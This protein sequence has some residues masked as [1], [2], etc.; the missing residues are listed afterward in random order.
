MKT[1]GGR[2]FW[3]DVYAF[4]DWRIQQNVLTGHFRLLDGD[5]FRHAS[6]TFKTCRRKLDEIRKARNLPPMKGKAVIVVHGIIRSSKSFAKM[7]EQLKKEGFTVIGFDYPSTRVEITKSAN[8]LHK[9]ITSLKGIEEINFVVHSMGG[10]V[11]RAY[12]INHR[13]KRIRRMVMLGVPNHGARMAD[14]LKK[15]PLFRLVLGPAGQQLV[16]DPQGVINSLPIPDFEFGIVAG[17]RGTIKGYNPLIPGDD[18]GTVSVS[19]ARLAGARDFIT[20]KCLHSFLM[21]HPRTIEFTSRFLREGRFR[22]HGA[23]HPIPQ[24]KNLRIEAN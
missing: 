5:D 7:R 4:H 16:S 6:G 2:Q 1:L 24:K 12:L 10:L 13:D 20:V 18:D 22:K 11:V 3:G 14:T 9:V 17:S 19:S 8:Y 21:S 23:R 15:N